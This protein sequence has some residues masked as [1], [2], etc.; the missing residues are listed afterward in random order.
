VRLTCSLGGRPRCR[1]PRTEPQQVE[2]DDGDGGKL[3]GVDRMVHS[4]KPITLL[5]WMVKIHRRSFDTIF[6]YVGSLS[7][8]D[9]FSRK[10]LLQRLVACDVLMVGPTL[11]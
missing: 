1:P 7:A 2:F 3:T 6:L 5:L 10:K 8:M 9:L 11:N 4:Y